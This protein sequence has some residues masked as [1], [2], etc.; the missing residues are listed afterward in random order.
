MFDRALQIGNEAL[1]KTPSAGMLGILVQLAGIRHDDAE[2]DRLVTLSRGTANEPHVLQEAG[3]A[4]LYE[5][6]AQRA[7]EL[8]RQAH[9]AAKREGAE[10][11]MLDLDATETRMLV[12][13]G[14]RDQAAASLAALPKMDEAMDA[15]YAMAEIGDPAKAEAIAAKRVQDEPNDQMLASEYAPAVHAAIAMRNGKPE[16]AIQIMA[17]DA[18]YEMRDPTVPYLLG[19]AYLAAGKPQQAI[20][21]FKKFLDNPGIDDPLTPLYALSYLGTAR[22]QAMQGQKAEAIATY[23]RFFDFWKNADPDLPVLAKA[24]TELAVLEPSAVSH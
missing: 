5:G 8:F 9:V 13:V 14:L 1:L 20:A 21:E 3:A 4:A 17:V 15:V 7:Q 16:D 2:I 11:D 24:R 18:P 22:A 23:H 6:N 19:Q 12:E 10:D